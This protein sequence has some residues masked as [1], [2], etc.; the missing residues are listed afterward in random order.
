MAEFLTNDGFCPICEA[1]TTFRAYGEYLRSTYLCERCG[2]VPRQRALM[3]AISRCYSNW[4]NLKIHESSPSDVA[5]SRKI[6]SESAAYTATQFEPSRPAGVM[7]DGLWQ[8]ENLEA[9]T[10]A[11]HSFDLVITQDVFEHVFHPHI[12]IREIART[13]RPGGAHIA[14]T[15]LVKGVKP[16]DRRARILEGGQIEHI[17]PAKFHQSPI[18]P[19]GSL[20]TVDWGYDIATY[21]DAH[22]PSLCTTI[23][24]IQNRDLGILGDLTEVLVSVKAP[25]P[26]I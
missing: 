13:L 15:P 21:F 12:A 8:N 26:A 7:V 6:K 18:D 10:F 11:D 14:T 23:F 4:R 17:R 24:M 9:Q 1:D 20:V 16:S 25:P 19:A 3:H 22:A 5:I 2:S